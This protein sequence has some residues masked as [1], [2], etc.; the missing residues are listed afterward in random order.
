LVPLRASLLAAGLAT[1][2]LPWIDQG[3]LLALGVIVLS[4]AAGAFWSPAMS[5]LADRAEE[6]GLDYAYGFA[7]ITL[8]WAPGA[9]VGSA[10]GGAVARAT[11]DAVVYL[12]LSAI[13]L[14]TLVTLAARLREP[15]LEPS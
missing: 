9:A 6:I 14:V 15:A 7:L 2:T 11:S 10:V 8:A 12:S 13:C 4:I 1:A 5:L 3:W